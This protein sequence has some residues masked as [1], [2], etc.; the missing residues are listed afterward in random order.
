[1]IAILKDIG[2]KATDTREELQ[3]KHNLLLVALAC[4]LAAPVWA[5]LSYVAGLREAAYIPLLFLPLLVAGAISLSV[6]K[7]DTFLFHTILAATFLCPVVMQWL[8]GGLL[9]GGVMILWAFL[10]PLVA[11]VFGQVK[12]A[13]LYMVLV[14]LA[15][16]AMGVFSGFFEQWGHFID[17]QEKLALITVNIAAAILVSYLAMQYFVRQINKGRQAIAQQERRA[18]SLLLNI[19]P[20]HVARE[21][22]ETGKTSTTLHENTTIIFTDFKDFT[23]FSE[24]FTPQELIEELAACFGKFDEISGRH[25]LEKIKTMGDAYMCVG[26]I[27]HAGESHAYAAERA[28][29]AA[30]E[31]AGYIKEV[32]SRK[33]AEGRA[34]WDVRIGVHTGDVVAGV[35]G[36]S[37]FIYDIWGDAVNV[38]NRLQT[39]S[40]EGRINISDT[41]YRLVKDYFTCTPRGKIAVKNKG[42]MDMYF[43]DGRISLH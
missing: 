22:T 17:K 21:L 29:L 7:R 14:V 5:W 27:Q 39:C 24:L 40:E 10:S 13:R 35:V 42:E 20:A 9:K 1:M 28:L 25:G 19:L 11:L 37:K 3:R 32:R 16:L 18:D 31:M 36:K 15:T 12:M 2:V 8:A 6:S 33:L 34:Y 43:V 26:G 23:Q 4:C 41:T 38:A 30:M